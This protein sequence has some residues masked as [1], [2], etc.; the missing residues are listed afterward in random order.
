MVSELGVSDE[1]V[2]IIKLMYKDVKA[3]LAEDIGNMFPNICIRL[4]VK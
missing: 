1:L 3:K 4:G 2:Q